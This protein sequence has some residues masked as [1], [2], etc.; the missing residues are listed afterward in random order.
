MKEEKKADSQGN[1]INSSLSPNT[2]LCSVYVQEPQHAD[3]FPADYRV[4]CW[5]MALHQ[6]QRGGGCGED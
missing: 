1:R 4:Y 6:D 2:K 3:K 5:K